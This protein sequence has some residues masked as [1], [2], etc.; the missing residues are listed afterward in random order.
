LGR[1]LRQHTCG[2]WRNSKLVDF[3]GTGMK[4]AC[5]FGTR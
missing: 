5:G 4:V 3:R 2:F 1:H